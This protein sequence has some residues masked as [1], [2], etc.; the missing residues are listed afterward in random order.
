MFMDDENLLF[1][2]SSEPSEINISLDSEETGETCRQAINVSP[3]RGAAVV[4]VTFMIGLAINLA[5]RTNAQQMTVPDTADYSKFRHDSSYHAR[6][7]CLLCHRREHN[8]ARPSVAGES[9]HLPCAGCHV[10]QFA[11]SQSPICGICHTNAQS[12]ALKPFPRLSTFTMKF[13]HA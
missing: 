9:N 4:T 10:K 11:D 7:P 2:R 3:L 8:A 13:D 1:S 12:G 5:I 6:L